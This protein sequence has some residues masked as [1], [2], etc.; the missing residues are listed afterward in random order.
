[1]AKWPSPAAPDAPTPNG[2]YHCSRAARYAR[3][4]R[5]VAL[6]IAAVMLGG[7]WAPPPHATACI[8]SPLAHPTMSTDDLATEQD[9][10]VRT[11]TEA[12]RGGVTRA[13]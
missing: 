3:V 12:A 8:M 11:S 13:R 7:C 10:R 6:A 5:H 9:A 2:G 1:M 4:M